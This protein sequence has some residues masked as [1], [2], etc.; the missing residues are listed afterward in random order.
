VTLQDRHCIAIFV[1]FDLMPDAETI[2]P[3]ILTSFETISGCNSEAIILKLVLNYTGCF[4]K[5]TNKL[6]YLLLSLF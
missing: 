5:K 1:A 2:I 3:G 4:R 6:Y